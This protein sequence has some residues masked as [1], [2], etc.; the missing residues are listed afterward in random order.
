MPAL[1][2]AYLFQR[3]STDA[4][5]TRTGA[6]PARSRGSTLNPSSPSAAARAAH[7]GSARSSTSRCTAPPDPATNPDLSAGLPGRSRARLREGDGRERSEHLPRALPE[8]RRG[9]RHPACTLDPMQTQLDSYAALAWTLDEHVSRAASVGRREIE[10]GQGDAGTSVPV[11]GSQ[12]AALPPIYGRPRRT[13]ASSSDRL[14]EEGADLVDPLGGMRF[15]T[16]PGEPT[17]RRGNRAA[18]EGGADRH[19]SHLD[20]RAH[21]RPPRLL[22]DQGGTGSR[23]ATRPPVGLRPC[24]RAPAG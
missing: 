24:R 17:Q 15:P 6:V 14:P 2:P 8:R 19:H 5:C 16:L 3:P 1:V 13:S 4:L 10:T 12:L 7:P 22:R 20:P 21:R 23:P 11:P 9:R 18:R